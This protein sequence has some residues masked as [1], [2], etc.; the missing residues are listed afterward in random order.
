M[1]FRL[2]RRPLVGD[3]TGCDRLS[4]RS[5]RPVAGT[6]PIFMFTIRDPD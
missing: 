5:R 3:T 1:V 6:L 4:A 2:Q